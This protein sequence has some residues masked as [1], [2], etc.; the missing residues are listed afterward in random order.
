[1]KK[2]NYWIFCVLFLSLSL[3]A[4]AITLVT[5]SGVFN[6]P[7][8]TAE[9]ANL[10]IN[11][12]QN[13]TLG[14][15][16]VDSH[17]ITINDIKYQPTTS[18]GMVYL[19]PNNVNTLN[20]SIHTNETQNIS[21]NVS[22][23]PTPRHLIFNKVTKEQLTDGIATVEINATPKQFVFY[24]DQTAPSIHN[25]TISKIADIANP[26][27]IRANI[28]EEFTV[29]SIKIQVTDPN[30][31]KT[32]YS[33][34]NTSAISSNTR[35][36][37]TWTPSVK[38]LHTFRMYATDDSGN[39]GIYAPDF[40]FTLT[41]TGA[42]PGGGGGGGGGGGSTPTIPDANKKCKITVVPNTVTF[43][44]NEIRKI[45]INNAGDQSF[46]PSFK[47]TG[48]IKKYLEIV[49]TV[50]VLPGKKGE[51]GIKY[52][53]NNFTEGEALL[54]LTDSQCGKID[55]DI[56]ANTLPQAINILDQ[57]LQDFDLRE[58][59]SEPVLQSELREKTPFFKIGVVF[60]IMILISAW[61][62]FNPITNAAK[63]QKY[64]KLALLVLFALAISFIAVLFV[65]TFIRAIN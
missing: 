12:T 61:L 3:G 41:T 7:I 2:T 57:L 28:T 35:Y 29:S 17:Y 31:V 24:H 51:V 55:V 52:Q 63:E 59:L 62:L 42:N 47:I 15:L 48:E 64:V 30:Q 45:I 8:I 38:G 14:N 33:M 25:V 50:T 10:T 53:A 32:N 58:F 44:Q 16:T 34:T 13:T 11:F 60:L 43:R 65:V 46:E 19:V 26:I 18:K 6:N 22:N 21:W 40:T 23:L 9:Q 37:L 5:G 20:F 1:M 54:T 27:N 49:N 36:L 39:T 4:S 56:E